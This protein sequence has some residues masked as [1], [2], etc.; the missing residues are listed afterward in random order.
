[1]RIFIMMMSLVATSLTS[2]AEI[3]FNIAGT[4]NYVWRGDTQTLDA[5]AI[6]GGFDYRHDSGAAIGVWTSNV[7]SE[8]EVDYYASFSKEVE[9]VDIELGAI[10][11]DYKNNSSANVGELYVSAS[12]FNANLTYYKKINDNDA[13]YFNDDA[14]YLSLGYELTAKEDIFLYFTLNH[15]FDVNDAVSSEDKYDYSISLTKT[16]P[17]VDLTFSVTGKEDG[18]SETFVTVSKLF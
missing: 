4:S 13:N 3:S 8:T 18:K 15:T 12:A 17:Q 2:H 6:Q 14:S 11:Y 1:M 5:P 10:Y 9:F 7:A 16:L